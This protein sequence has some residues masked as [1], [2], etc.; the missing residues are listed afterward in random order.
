MM[1]YD[2]RVGGHGLCQAG[3]AGL[4]STSMQYKYNTAITLQH[5][6][7]IQHSTQSILHYKYKSV[8]F[9]TYKYNAV[10]RKY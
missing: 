9:T 6:V 3:A 10:L 4:A 7:H 2:T 1:Q 5:T 8:R